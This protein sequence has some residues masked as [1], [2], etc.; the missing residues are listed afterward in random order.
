VELAGVYTE[1]LVHISAL[2][3][4]FYHF[5]RVRH[6]LIGER[7]GTTYRLGDEVRVRVVRVDLDDRKIDLELE[8]SETGGKG[9]PKKKSGGSRR[10]QSP[11]S[12]G[13][14]GGKKD[15]GKKDA[16]KEGANKEGGNKGAVV[17]VSAR[18]PVVTADQG[19]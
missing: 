6:T 14:K 11:K 19:G 9:G 10:R 2:G 1:G 15:A 3:G 5:D 17:A 8:D 13:G 16:G 12:D 18:S 4:D 7:T